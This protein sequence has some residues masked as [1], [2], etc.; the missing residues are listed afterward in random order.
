MPILQHGESIDLT[1][2]AESI[3]TIRSP[4][5]GMVNVESP[6]GTRIWAGAESDRKVR[7]KAGV[8]RITAAERNVF[9]EVSFADVIQPSESDKQSIGDYNSF[10]IYEE[11]DKSLGDVFSGAMTG[12]T[13]GTTANAG[14]TATFT[15]T[16]IQ[17]DIA[18]INGAMYY[19]SGANQAASSQLR[20]VLHGNSPGRMVSMFRHGFRAEMRFALESDQP[21]RVVQF[22]WFSRGG[23]LTTDGMTSGAGTL[24]VG[25]TAYLIRRDP[26]A[27]IQRKDEIATLATGKVYTISADTTSGQLVHTITNNTD[28]VVVDTRTVPK[29]TGYQN[30]VNDMDLFG[31]T[32]SNAKFQVW[33]GVV[34]GL[35]TLTVPAV[36]RLLTMDAF[37]VHC[38]RLR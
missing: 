25:Q 35:H 36:T 29:W 17:S 16:A 32:P 5:G 37:Y 34:G 1:I 20:Y 2:G 24:I 10:T 15:T 30:M 13:T 9:Y 23:T 11:F 4:N 21:N 33:F 7:V 27:G 18:G 12:I 31:S 22:G 14:M 28:G 38:P 3:I 26:D 6:I 8:T 19:N